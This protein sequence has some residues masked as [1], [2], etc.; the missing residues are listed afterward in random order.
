MR[1]TLILIGLLAVIAAF[2]WSR[3]TTPPARIEAAQGPIGSL[4]G[5]RQ[6]LQ[7]LLQA[8]ADLSKPT[9]VNYYLYYQDR[10]AADSA[11]ARGSSAPLV[12]SVQRAADNSAWLCLVTGTMVPSESN[13]RAHTTRL[14]AL[15]QATGGQ[16]DGW[17]AAVTK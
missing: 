3:R 6:V 14:V 13:I 2:T 4:E 7:Q 12:A 9:E 16:Y 10:A 17:E 8:G 1:L 5:D 11:A 15:A